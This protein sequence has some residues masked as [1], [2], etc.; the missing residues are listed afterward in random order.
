MPTASA[1]SRDSLHLVAGEDETY[2]KNGWRIC[3]RDDDAAGELSRHLKVSRPVA[4]VL[5]NRGFSCADD[6]ALDAVRR[7]VKP[8]RRHLIDPAKLPGIDKAADRIVQAIN[9]NEKIALYGDYDVDGITASAILWHA[10]VTLGCDPE[11]VETYIPHRIDEGYGLNADAVRQLA[12][13]GAKVIVTVDCGITAV[14]EAAVAKEVGVDL[15]ITDHHEPKPGDAGNPALPDAFALVHPRLPG[16]EYDNGDLVGAGVAFKLAWEVGRRAAG[17][18]KTSPEMAQFL[19]DAMA[20]A[21]LGTVADV[22]PLTGENRVI[23][24][25][26]LGGLT[27]TRLDGVIALID[28]TGLDRDKVDSYD[29][30]F[31]LGPRLNACGRMGHARDAL[32]MLTVATPGEARDIATRLESENRE[33]QGVERSTVKEAAKIIRENGWF[34]DDARGIVVAGSGWHPGVV[35]IVASR[36]V[37]TF[38][39]P[40]IVLAIND[41]GV[42]TGSGRS[43]A[44]FNLA[45]A[46]VKCDDLLTS[47]G[48]HHAAA[49]LKLP[50]GDIDAFRE[51][52]VSICN[53]ELAGVDLQPT[54]AVDVEADV[55]AIDLALYGELSR[56]GPFGRGNEKPL[57]VFRN[58]TVLTARA[59]GNGKHL[60][61][62]LDDGRG[63]RVKGI[64][65]GCGALATTLRGGDTIDVAARLSRNEWQG[66]VSVELE[67]KDLARSPLRWG[68]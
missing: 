46:L 23:V 43:F 42:A 20:L 5:H 57:L 9:A 40:T 30:G 55:S 8:E 16:S 45:A 6:A 26:G 66:R 10:L 35:G 7:F 65:F 1:V 15:I 17:G 38:H 11:Q 50:A 49:G 28:S 18:G 60:Q 22:A 64:A 29:V 4:Q 41:D 27:K 47:H 68:A 14:E 56:L 3:G 2:P 39:R 67:V 48:G 34:A 54:L 24:M 52:F 21:A 63:R 58:L 32:T 33:R 31:K 59:V 61:L 53:D 12:E 51:R 13:N 44:G 19:L 25:S 36:L 62:Q 37:E